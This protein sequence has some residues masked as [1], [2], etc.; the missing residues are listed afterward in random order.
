MGFCADYQATQQEDAFE[1][2]RMGTCFIFGCIFGVVMLIT[3]ISMVT[4]PFTSTTGYIFLGVAIIVVVATLNMSGGTYFVIDKSTQ[5]MNIVRGRW[6]NS[7]FE[8]L[9]IGHT[10]E[11]QQAYLTMG[12]SGSV[13]HHH[14]PHGGY[15]RRRSGPTYTVTIQ[16][17]KGMFP[18]TKSSDN[19]NVA[20]KQAFCQRLNDYF[21]K[22][23]V[24]MG[25]MIQ[26]MQNMQ[27][28]QQQMQQTM[29]QMQQMQ[30]QQQ[31]GGAAVPV[32]QQPQTQMMMVNGQFSYFFFF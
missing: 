18:M 9:N 10:S 12:S 20:G 2:S 27:Q 3:G 15:H 23:T 8:R 22:P 14:G 24:S 13:H 5:T 32:Q 26:T 19:I 28:T 16:T 30:I 11:Y 17:T 25:G 4:S 7:H 1:Y 31:M 21:G 29:Q 6:C